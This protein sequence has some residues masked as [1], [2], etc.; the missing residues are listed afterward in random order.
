MSWTHQRSNLSANRKRTA[1]GTEVNIS[2][3]MQEKCG[4][5]SEHV[6][7][8]VM[9]EQDRELCR[10]MLEEVSAEYVSLAVTAVGFLSK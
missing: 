10:E 6:I 4:E 8:L 9:Q 3:R 2:Q 1:F 7:S 5:F